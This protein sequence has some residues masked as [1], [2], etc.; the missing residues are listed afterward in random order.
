MRNSSENILSHPLS[1]RETQKVLL[2]MCSFPFGNTCEQTLYAFPGAAI[3]KNHT[4]DGL[5]QQTL[6][7]FSSGEQKSAIKVSAGP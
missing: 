4:Q 1:P 6:T 2:G 7:V 3:A 5:K